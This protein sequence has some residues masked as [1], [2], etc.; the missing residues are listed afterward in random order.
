MSDSVSYNI[1]VDLKELRKSFR[2]WEQKLP[3]LSK[4]ILS[5][6][7]EAITGNIKQYWLTGYALNVRSGRLRKSISYKMIGNKA[8]DIGTLGSNVVYARIH[9]K[10]GVIRPVRSQYLRFQVNG[11][12][13]TTK[14][15]RIPARPYVLPAI[16][17]FMHSG[18]ANKLAEKTTADFI[19]IEW[20]AA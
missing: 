15:V 19:R 2:N 18:R 7:G 20:E 10:G 11:R 9:E 4:L 13:V 12:W 3:K 14:E 5:R 16:Q 8:V 6:T 17:H 1:K